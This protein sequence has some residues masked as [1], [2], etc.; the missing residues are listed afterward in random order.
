V[1]WS[2]D[3]ILVAAGSLTGKVTIWGVGGESAGQQVLAI[4]P[5]DQ[6]QPIGGLAWSPDGETLAVGSWDGT[7]ILW[8]ITQP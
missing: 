5:F 8:D 6:L 2:P 1:V 4:E 7:L 3:G